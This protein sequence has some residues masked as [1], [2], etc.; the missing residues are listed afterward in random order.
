MRER[1][2][3][4]CPTMESDDSIDACLAYTEALGEADKGPLAGKVRLENPRAEIERQ[5]RRH[6]HR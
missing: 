5:R 1:L 3:L 6:R 4:A 2:Q